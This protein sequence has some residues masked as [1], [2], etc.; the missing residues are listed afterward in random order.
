[1]W[2]AIASEA[3]YGLVAPQVTKVWLIASFEEPW[4]EP[5]W[6][7]AYKNKMVRCMTPRNSVLCAMHCQIRC[8]PRTL[9]IIWYALAG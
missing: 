2:P 7:T 5:G 8:T 6:G 3:F 9:S 4:W 1:M